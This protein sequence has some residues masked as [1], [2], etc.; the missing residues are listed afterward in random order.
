MILIIGSKGFI[1]SYLKE[2]LTIKYETYGCDVTPSDEPYYFQVDFDNPNF[3]QLFRNRKLE[4]CIN[5]A[6]SANVQNSM[7]SP[8]NDF[9]A[10]LATLSKLL[11]AVTKYNR[12]CKVINISS[13]AVYGNPPS[14][15]IFVDT[16]QNPLSPYGVHKMLGD[17][18]MS[19][20]CKIFDL[21]TSSVRIF[22][23]YGNGQKKL[24]LWDCFLKLKNAEAGSP[25]KFYGTGLESRDYIHITDIVNQ[26]EL[27]IKNASFEGEVYNIA[28]G[29]EVFIKDVVATMQAE[30]NNASEVIFDG[31]TRP[32]DPLNWRADI[33]PMLNWGYSKSI[34]ME[35]GIKEYVKW[36]SENA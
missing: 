29:E 8:F 17:K 19:E 3:S 36:A 12:R 24:F 4:Y 21:N 32:G 10:N 20:Y 13:A 33:T 26:I 15:P 18:L 28:N 1:G 2:A 31:Q 7:I 11:E 25:I 6:G 16:P 9:T 23:A 30:L 27:V 34:S 14:L 35:D 5:C 22:S